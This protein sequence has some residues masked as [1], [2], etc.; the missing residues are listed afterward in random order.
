MVL[1]SW[2]CLKLLHPGFLRGCSVV[3][4]P[5]NDIP[6]TATV[7]FA[8]FVNQILS[9]LFDKPRYSPP[10]RNAGYFSF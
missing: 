8:N 2:V 7:M 4:V 6:V 1:C 9:T 5:S 3:P 10:F